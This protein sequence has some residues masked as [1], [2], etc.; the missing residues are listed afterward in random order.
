MKN[1]LITLLCG[2]ALTAPLAQAQTI[3]DNFLT[4][5]APNYDTAAIVGQNPTVTGFTGAWATPGSS[6]AAISATGLTYSTVASAGGSVLFPAT[7]PAAPNAGRVTRDLTT[8][9][10]TN[11]DTTVYMSFMM[12]NSLANDTTQY[13]AFEL[14]TV[15]GGDATRTFR[16]G[17]GSLDADFGTT[18]YGF[19]VNNNPLVA[20]ERANLNISNTATNFFVVKFTLSS[21]ALNDSVTV[22]ANPTNLGSESLSGPG[23]SITGFTFS[24]NME[25]VQLASFNVGGSMGF[26]EFRIGDSWQAVTTVPEPSTSALIAI[27]LAALTIL[28]RRRARA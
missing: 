14:N 15:G 25:R 23:D 28:R 3:V 13:R 24:G 11:S 19:R 2:F 21:T 4:G 27:S 16:L 12:E 1:I 7:L 20:A 10:N 6:T 17:L 18:N 5:G 26:D 9:I 8:A 22:W